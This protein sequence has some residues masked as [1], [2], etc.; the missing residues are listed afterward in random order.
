[1]A[2][3]NKSFKQK[4]QIC[5][6]RNE[7]ALQ[8]LR[9]TEENL[10]VGRVD[11]ELGNCQFKV[12]LNDGRDVLATLPGVFKKACFIH[13]DSIIVVEDGLPGMAHGIRFILCDKDVRQLVLEGRIHA[14]LAD[15]NHS[16]EK[17][18]DFEFEED[19]DID[20]DDI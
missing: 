5:R 2:K 14:S 17:E 4:T 7:G 13:T 18:D 15:R 8:I 10:V 11:K 19:A 6:N 16:D 20:V 3:K 12:R 1:M 9:T